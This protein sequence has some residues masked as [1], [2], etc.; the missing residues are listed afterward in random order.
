V[1]EWLKGS[2][3]QKNRTHLLGNHDLA[4]LDQRFICSGFTEEKLIIIRNSKVD[5]T[6]LKLYH[7]ID[8]WLATHAGLSY[9]FYEAYAGSGMTPNDLLETFCI[10]SELKTKLYSCS[11]SRG[12]SDKYSGI[13][14]CDYNEF[15]D[16]PDLKQIFGHTRGDL[17]QT[18]NHICL[19]TGLQYYAVFN[20][21]MK[22]KRNE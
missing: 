17:R 20:G 7:W 15:K 10:D 4:Y 6:K 11:S 12:G 16:I 2:L 5:L 18:D 9:D 21:E 13:V 14:W 22:V 1:S 19:D 8:D 3:K